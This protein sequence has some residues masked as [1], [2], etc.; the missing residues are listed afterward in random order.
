MKRQLTQNIAHELKTPV[1]SIQGYLETILSNPDLPAEKRDFFLERCFSQ[2]S[3][4]T[5]LLR[6][7]SVL[8]RLDEASNMFDLADI[9]IPNLIKEIEKESAKKWKKKELLQK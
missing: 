1:S 6:D 9:Q 2:S 3:R 7:I 4:L 5:H 8:N